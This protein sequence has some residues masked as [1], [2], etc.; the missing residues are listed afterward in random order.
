MTR[1][2]A[3]CLA[4]S[5]VAAAPLLRA[6]EI[7]PAV[8]TVWPDTVSGGRLTWS[9]PLLQ[10]RPILAAPD[11]GAACGLNST[12]PPERTD[13]RLTQQ[14][15]ANCPC[16]V[17]LRTPLTVVGPEA[18]IASAL[19]VLMGA[20]GSVQRVRRLGPTDAR[21]LVAAEEGGSGAKSAY[22]SLG[23]WHVL[24]GYDHLGFAIALTLLL[25]SWRRAVRAITAF[26][27]GHSLTL[28]AASLGYLPPAGPAVETMIALSVVLLAREVVMRTRGVESLSARRP[29][30]I[31]VGFGL[32]HGLGFAGAL[33]DI[34]LPESGRLW[35]LALFNVGVEAGQLL[36]LAATASL[37]LAAA[38]WS[39]G[40]RVTVA[41][42]TAIGGFGVYWL[43]G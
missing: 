31:A 9:V 39:V 2:R 20:D 35:A 25:A 15:R 5:L 23:F 10:G 12:A 21:P 17:L 8:L 16:D 24:E 41:L 42:A 11:F 29:E 38:H 28:A 36:V 18:A 32:I 4:L 13:T 7:L 30:L 3:V 43:I 22:F 34:G 27:V 33:A 37:V 26:S 40:E 6:H 19:A 14:L 1:L